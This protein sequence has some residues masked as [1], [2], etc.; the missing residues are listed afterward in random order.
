MADYTNSAPATA[1][2]RVLA[3]LIDVAIA[4]GISVIFGLILG[5][6][7]WDSTIGEIVGSI[8]L[9]S[10]E[11]LPFLGGQ[12]IGKKLM[13]IRAVTEDGNSL[14]NNYGASVI[15]SLSMIIFPYELY[16]MS[17][18]KPRLGDQWAK[19]RVVAE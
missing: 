5:H 10:K 7:T 2:N 12:S 11:A 1:G 15:R 4:Y 13:K 16:L 14:L 17:N 8:Y 9:L 18:D 19:T 3:A 6:N